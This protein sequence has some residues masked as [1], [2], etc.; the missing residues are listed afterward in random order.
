M[1]TETIIESPRQSHPPQDHHEPAAPKKPDVSGARKAAIF[2]L[3]L[4]EDAAAEVFKHLGEDEVQLVLKELASLPNVKSDVVNNIIEEFN[5]LLVARSYVATGGVEYAK[6]LLN[7]SFGAETAKRLTDKVVNSADSANFDALKKTDPQQLV[8]LFQN[9]HPQTVAVV[10]AYLDPSTAADVI[11]QMPDE[12]RGDVMLRLASLQTVSQDVVKRISTVFNQK[13][14]SVSSI[15][16]ASV[17]GIRSV[18]EICNRL[19]KEAMRGLLEQIEG[20]SPE[21]SLE[22]RNLMVT[23][24]DILLVDDVG[25]REIIQRV[26]KKVLALALKGTVQ[27]LQDRFFTNM[28]SRA[29]EMMKEEME[30]MGQVKLKDVNGAQREIV[31]V[32]RELDEQGVISLGGGGGDADEYVS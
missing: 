6:R 1:T 18:A 4:G 15:S 8:K 21:L 12:T 30:F 31:E 27:E 7:K 22:I 17:G 25:I 23:F 13:L 20:S 28:S 2:C 19:D 10:L 26:D 29:V 11:R 32:L 14:T 9:E 5:Q 16:R 24:D 3:S